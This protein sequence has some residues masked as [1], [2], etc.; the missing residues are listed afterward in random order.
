MAA[1]RIAVNTDRRRKAGALRKGHLQSSR[2]LRD[3]DGRSGGEEEGINEG[4]GQLH[5]GSYDSALGVYVR[6]CS[7][8]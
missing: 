7:W 8:Q 1:K 3:G 6:G 2:L 4:G 5:P